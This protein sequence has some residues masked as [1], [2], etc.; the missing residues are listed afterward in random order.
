MKLIEKKPLGGIYAK[1]YLPW[2]PD[3]AR[4]DGSRGDFIL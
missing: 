4:N 3:Q 1:L 2:I